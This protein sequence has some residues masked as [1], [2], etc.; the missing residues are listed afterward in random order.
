MFLSWQPAS[1]CALR[2]TGVSA[3]LGRQGLKSGDVLELDRMA[4]ASR[5][6]LFFPPRAGETVTVP[7]LRGNR[8]LDLTL[9]FG[10]VPG[11]QPLGPLIRFS[12]ILLGLIALWR[13]RDKASLGL[14]V[15]F[16]GI[17]AILGP[18]YAVLS[19][20]STYWAIVTI[21]L[22]GAVS[23]VGLVSM[24]IAM[25]SAYLPP[26]WI[27]IARIATPLVALAHFGASLTDYLQVISSGCFAA[28]ATPVQIAAFSAQM[29]IAMTLLGAA[30]RMAPPAERSRVR[31]IYWSTCVGFLGPFFAIILVLFDLPRPTF[32]WLNLTILSIPFGYT[33][34]VLRHRLIDVGFVINRA[35]VYGAMTTVIVGI[36]AIAENLL[37]NAAIGKGTSLTLELVVAGLLGLSFNAL[38]KRIDAAVDQVFFKKKHDA[39]AA[40]HRFAHESAFIERPGALLDR[41]ADELYLH[42]GAHSVSLYERDGE[43]YRRVRARGDAASPEMV[44]VDDPAFV[45]MRA[46]LRDL[47][48]DDVQS[49]LG[50]RGL[51]VPMVVRGALIGAVVLGSRTSEEPYAPDERSLLLFVAH[52]IAAALHAMQAKEHAELVGALATG[53][54]DAGAAQ[55]RARELRA[56]S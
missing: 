51:A 27:R 13:G 50:P 10:Q 28:W 54:I 43:G 24:T 48:L 7:V 32:D 1:A 31:W 49:A 4:P 53:L 22:L 15:F 17:S 14:G 46:T 44:D 47:D 12:F 34:A 5:L 8:Q 40:L 20:A 16:C 39:E 2:I 21:S 38:H 56:L 18:G 23:L 6:R 36:L 19:V 42:A 52:E 55:S 11:F 37:A 45:R 41:A 33:Y 29:L 35:L 26:L 25:T 3:D 9:T 30:S